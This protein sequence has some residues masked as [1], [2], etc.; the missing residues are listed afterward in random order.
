[1]HAHHNR[2]PPTSPSLHVPRVDCRRC[3]HQANRQEAWVAPTTMTDMYSE[4]PHVNSRC[5]SILRQKKP[6]R[7]NA[8]KYTHTFEHMRKYNNKLPYHCFAAPEWW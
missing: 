8:E 4:L 1:M 7:R 3:Y 5:I 2:Y 6:P